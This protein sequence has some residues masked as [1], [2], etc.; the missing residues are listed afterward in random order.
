LRINPV[1]AR[2]HIVELPREENEHFQLRKYGLWALKHTYNRGIV[3]RDFRVP[4][5]N[6]LA[7]FLIWSGHGHSYSGRTQGAVW[8]RLGT[9][10]WL[11]A[12]CHNLLG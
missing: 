3:F 5:Q 2:I 4:R 8:T 11:E 9:W 10:W 6:L 7:Q 12:I 1:T